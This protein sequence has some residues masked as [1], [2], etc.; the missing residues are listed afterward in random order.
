MNLFKKVRKIQGFVYSALED[1][2]RFKEAKA[3]DLIVNENRKPPYIVVDHSFDTT[4]VTKWPGKLFEVEIINQSKEKDLNK[5]LVD[6]IW[7]TRTL[8]V[9][10]LKEVPV[11][12]LFGQNGRSISRIIDLTRNLTQEQVN[13]LAKYD[14]KSRREL[15]VKV[16]RNWIK[17]SDPD[18]VYLNEDHENTLKVFLKNQRYHSPIREGL[19]VISS[20]FSVRAEE[21]NKELAFG[22]DEEGESFLQP[23]WAHACEVLLQAGISYEYDNLLTELEKKTLRE[24]L[25]EVFRVEEGNSDAFDM[26]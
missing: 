16:W 23:I 22:I 11:S 4:I 19:S 15:Y 24:P 21:I 20:Q 6:N 7:Y 12:Q 5:G 9:R 3:G 1:D 8:G 2:K 13:T 26:C 25:M 10:I 17:M 18:Y 14:L